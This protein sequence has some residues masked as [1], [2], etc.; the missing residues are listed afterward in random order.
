[1]NPD[2]DPNTPSRSTVEWSAGVP[3]ILQRRFRLVVE[4][5]GE[6]GP[7]HVC[8]SGRA[9]IGSHEAADLRLEDRT[10]S[11]FHCEIEISDER[12]RI[13]DLD[14]RNGTRVDG[15]QVERAS[16]ND[17]SVIAIGQSR[18]RFEMSPDFSETPVSVGE[19]FG[20]LIGVTPEMR[21]V[22]ALLERAA[23]SSAPVLLYGEPGTGKATAA[24]AVHNLSD[25]K[26]APF[27]AVDMASMSASSQ[28]AALYGNDS[29]FAAAR[30][31]TVFLNE[32]AALDT[33]L[34]SRLARTLTD[35]GDVRLITSTSRDLRAEV[36]TKRFRAG[37]LY[38]LAVIEV[39]VP[40]LR[41]RPADIVRLA[42]EFLGVRSS[43]APES[44]R[45]LWDAAFAEQL[46]RHAW[47][48]NVTELRSYIDRCIALSTPAPLG[49][50]TDAGP[51]V[52]TSQPFRDARD[53]WLN[54]F[55]RRYLEKLVSEHGG[56]VSAAARAAKLDRAYFYRLLWRHGLR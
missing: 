39:R 40:P 54:H 28:S 9:V 20:P 47:P 24:E 49:A 51:V 25:R 37:L 30:G 13:K 33:E 53:K 36:N 48:G 44:V 29:V 1:M 42:E 32:I 27:L 43:V 19:S 3:K 15:V 22:F 52:D 55:E 8:E 35:I 41:D 7:A 11:R 4:N 26:H 46:R 10:V 56:N 38:A 12:A 21:R 34:Q 45:D 2:S 17:G 5:A 6:S 23:Q 31:G 18:V 16:L 14:S 50:L